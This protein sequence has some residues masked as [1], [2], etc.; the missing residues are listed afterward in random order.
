MKVAHIITRLI[1]G[2]AQENT[3]Y[4]CI[5]LARRHGATVR[6]FTGPTTGPEGSLVKFAKEQGVDL[7]E[8]PSLIRAINPL[9]DVP[10]YFQIRKALKEF[11]PDVVHT[12]SA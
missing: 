3:V 12:H 2:G 4:S 11:A 10:A 7:V 8:I 6:L 9:Y 5:D 1:L